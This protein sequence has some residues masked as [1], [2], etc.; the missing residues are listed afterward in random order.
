LKQLRA[1]LEREGIRDADAQELLSTLDWES[2]L[3]AD[4]AEVSRDRS[5][6]DH[7]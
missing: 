7:E 3:V 5:I 2:A 6:P 4:G 1:D